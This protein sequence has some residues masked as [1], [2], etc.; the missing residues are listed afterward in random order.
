MEVPKYRAQIKPSTGVAGQASQFKI[1]GG[2][3]SQGQAAQ[4]ELFASLA[5]EA[6][7]WGQ[8]A[9]SIHR[10]NVVNEAVNAAEDQ[11][12]IALR[13]AQRQPLNNPDYP[14][15]GGILGFFGDRMQSIA[16][17][18]Y[19]GKD[20]I[21]ASKI[22]SQVANRIQTAQRTINTHNA[23]RLINENQAI[24]DEVIA[25]NTNIAAIYLDPDW[26]GNLDNLSPESR[27]AIDTI[28][29][30]L[31]EARDN[32]TRTNSWVGEKQRD[33]F[34]QISK[35][36][37]QTRINSLQRS[38]DAEDLIDLLE[39]PEKKAFF[40][41]SVGDRSAFIEELHNKKEALE[42]K[43]L[44]EVEKN[45][46]DAAR[47]ERITQD[48]NRMALEQKLV[49]GEL[50]YEDVLAAANS[51][52]K[53]RGLSPEVFAALAKAA[54]AEEYL[55]RNSNS[56][57]MVEVYQSL[58]A[59]REEG[60]VAKR[61][62]LANELKAELFA[63]VAQGRDSRINLEDFKD[64]LSRTT[65][66]LKDITITDPEVKR[67]VD[68]IHNMMG[69]VMS[70]EGRLL[71]ILDDPNAR[72]QTVQSVYEAVSTYYELIDKHNLTAANALAQVRKK[73]LPH[74]APGGLSLPSLESTGRTIE[75]PGENLGRIDE[76][77]Q[78]EIDRIYAE[79]FD[80][81]YEN[82]IG[83]DDIK[84]LTS[85]TDSLVGSLNITNPDAG[86]RT[87][88][89][90]N[91]W[92]KRFEEQ[93]VLNNNA[94]GDNDN[95]DDGLLKEIRD[96]LLALPETFRKNQEIPTSGRE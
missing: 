20:P 60:D 33:L 41:L 17:E 38:T 72:A 47:Q 69:Y 36:S 9:S 12:E 82:K 40:H 21:L 11:I 30:A 76:F 26:D 75:V 94:D 90:S 93:P 89:P 77:T 44:A 53:S 61:E 49:E 45:I 6:A 22:N 71:P 79:I 66:I 31:L 48:D 55:P 16:S 91:A 39:D 1:P 80:L 35:V 74:L 96:W 4:G 46:R 83:R 7:K 56:E 8:L 86:I 87:T 65:S 63:E 81:F 32:G 58:N 54:K 52:P 19:T 29:L 42:N 68:T 10:N 25:R 92:A 24:L 5:G 18:A 88:I 23:T 14:K 95:E 67:G 85:Q 43:E 57:F 70:P 84:S 62:A 37:V 78:I 13:E 51:L 64:I 50:T 15:V 34:K 3:L 2:A 59:T 73:Y 27:S 28:N